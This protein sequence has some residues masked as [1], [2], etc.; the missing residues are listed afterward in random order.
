MAEHA[1]T[2]ALAVS[3]QR[4]PYP[5]S[6]RV[7]AL[8]RSRGALPL[9]VTA[10]DRL[11]L[12][13]PAGEA[14]WVGLVATPGAPSSRVA[15]VARL[16]SGERVDLATG[17]APATDPAPGAFPVPPRFAVEGIA[18]PDGGWWAL[19]LAPPEPA[20][21]ACAGLELAVWTGPPAPAPAGSGR[22]RPLHDPTGP[23]GPAS[24]PPPPPAA[25]AP[26]GPPAVLGVDLVDA[27]GFEA[28]T[29]RRPPGPAGDDATYGGWRLP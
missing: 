22:P 8:P 19:T 27:A 1:V 4:Y 12:A 11:L 9:A 23:S 14:F 3:F 21:P 25:G 5:P 28:A 17:A 26:A 13:C 2:A 20:A 18:R 7:E 24:R 16:A 6:G 29:G 10:P 15:V